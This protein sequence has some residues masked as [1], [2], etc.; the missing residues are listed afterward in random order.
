MKF[1]KKFIEFMFYPFVIFFLMQGTVPLYLQHEI[2]TF[3]PR[4]EVNCQ[5][6]KKRNNLP[7]Y[8][9]ARDYVNLASSIVHNTPHGLCQCIDYSKCI[10]DTYQD[11]ARE[12][13]RSD[14]EKSIRI[15]FGTD[16]EFAR[17]Y[18]IWIDI[19]ESGEFVP[20]E[21]TNETP[22]LETDKIMA[23]S[24]TSLEEKSNLDI[25]K[26]NMKRFLV[27][28]PGEQNLHPT[29]ELYLSKEGNLFYFALSNYFMKF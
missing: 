27:S 6:I 13:N 5:E 10:F 17:P 25:N 22:H 9:S 14:L 24:I 3:K 11:L 19:E 1:R 23:Y 2:N 18:H 28:S 8:L 20:Y 15:A 26:I 16:L 4:V 7:K 29:I 12:N 21:S